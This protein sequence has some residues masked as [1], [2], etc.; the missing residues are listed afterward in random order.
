MQ[1]RKIRLVLLLTLVIL[2]SISL[3]AC[4]NQSAQTK[5]V[6]AT[7]KRG[8]IVQTVSADGSLSLVQDRKLTFEASGKITEVNVTEGDRVTKG[9]VLVKLD[10]TSLERTVK[11]AEL[12]VSAAE[13]AVKSAEIDRNQAGQSVKSA[14]NALNQAQI[15]VT[16]AR[17]NLELANNSYWRVIAPNPYQT[18]QF[19]VP[20][21]LDSLRIAEERLKEAQ[22]EFKKAV[23]GQ[24]YSLPY[25]EE[26]LSNAKTLLS[27][28]ATKLGWG[29]EAGTRPAFADYWTLR[30]LEL[31][32]NN[33]KSALD[34]ANGAVVTARVAL[35]NAKDVQNKAG[36]AV[37]NAT[38]NLERAK[39][40]LDRA[41]DELKKTTMT[42]PFDGV[43][44]RVNVKVGEVL[45]SVNYASTVGIEIIDSVRMEISVKVDEVD[46]PNVKLGQKATITVDAL[47]DTKLEG[48]VAAISSLP[49]VEGGVISYKVKTSLNVPQEMGLKSGM[50]ATADI[51]IAQ[52]SN[53]LLVPNRA[54][55]KDSQGNATVEVVVNGQTQMRTVVTGISDNFNTEIKEGLNEGDVVVEA[56][57]QPD[58][59]GGILGGF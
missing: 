47:P 8:E 24:Q 20:D 45:S 5:L 26:K 38:N 17:T 22:D 49:D 54:I 13:I 58:T 31:Q 23:Q 29:I 9:Q 36:L 10:T 46:V 35:D 28:A 30:S 53:V 55:D 34:N 11:S 59:S 25:I 2:A 42:A 41:R 51:I 15:G 21:S 27:D 33:A 3:A 19:V 14:E 40:E 1:R 57:I 4:S 18:Y 39:G 7:V 56:R 48:V 52:R 16:I 32:I 37:D 43:I 12:G 50:S 44:A 6:T